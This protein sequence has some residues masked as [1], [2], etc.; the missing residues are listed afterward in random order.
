[1]KQAIKTKWRPQFNCTTCGDEIAGPLTPSCI[2]ATPPFSIEIVEVGEVS[3]FKCVS[4]LNEAGKHENSC[5]VQHNKVHYTNIITVLTSIMLSSL[6]GVL[7]W[8]IIRHTSSKLKFND[9]HVNNTMFHARQNGINS[10]RN[11]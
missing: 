11:I 7:C 5:Q 10:N 6:V 1:M 4:T 9:C 2:L 3:T 8:Q